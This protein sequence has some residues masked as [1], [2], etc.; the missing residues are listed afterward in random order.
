MTSQRILFCF[1]KITYYTAHCN[2]IRQIGCYNPRMKGYS[3]MF[4]K[5]NIIRKSMIRHTVPE[6]SLPPQSKNIPSERALAVAYL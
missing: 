6:E 2:L 3:I 1:K 5:S 4:S